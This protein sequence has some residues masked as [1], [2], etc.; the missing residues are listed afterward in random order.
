MTWGN[1]TEVIWPSIKAWRDNTDDTT[2][3]DAKCQA[4]KEADM[5]VYA[6]SPVEGTFGDY[7]Q[8]AIQFGYVTLFAPTYPMVVVLAFLSNL[9]EIR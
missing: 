7:N 2:V 5:P 9:V 1:F 3:E 4:E 6:E 8:L